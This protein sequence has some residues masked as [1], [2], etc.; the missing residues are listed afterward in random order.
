MKKIADIAAYLFILSVIVLS[1]VAIFGVWEFFTRDV[2]YKSFLSIGLLAITAVIVLVADHFIDRQKTTI[3]EGE[4]G[5]F[6]EIASVLPNQVFRSLRIGTLSILIISVSILALLGIL[7]IWE[8]MSGTVL[9]K[10][11]GSIAIIAFASLIIT[12]VSL[13]RENN[14]FFNKRKKFS[15]VGIIILLIFGLIFASMFL[16]FL[17]RLVF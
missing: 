7:A 9:H 8:V 1:T 12:I 5:E 3:Q 4:G 6:Q 17:G 13:D 10:S 15:K 16:S 11:S 14:P 2:I